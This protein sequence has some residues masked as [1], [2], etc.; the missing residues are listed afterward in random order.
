MPST[1][2]SELIPPEAFLANYSLHVQAIANALRQLVKATVPEVQER[3]AVGWQL[4]GYRVPD[5]S[6]SRY[7]CFISPLATEARLG[8][9]YGVLLSDQAQLEGDGSQVRY[10][11]VRSLDEL[12]PTQ[13]GSLIAEAA[14]V[15]L[16]RGSR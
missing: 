3:V 15:A 11:S 7:F 1:R 4:I 10:V 12:N 13:L 9:E 5:G 8:F 16:S 2:K 14:M 6:R